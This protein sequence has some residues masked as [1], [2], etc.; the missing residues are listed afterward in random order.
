MSMSQWNQRRRTV[1]VH[2]TKYEIQYDIF[3]FVSVFA[4]LKIQTT[5]YIVFT[6][7]V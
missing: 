5:D 4:S 6:L 1:Y 7:K 3:M 2:S